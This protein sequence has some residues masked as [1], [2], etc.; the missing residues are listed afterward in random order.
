MKYLLLLIIGFFTINFAKSQ[1]IPSS[2][3]QIKYA[4]MALSEDA[5]KEATVLGY[6][7]NGELITLKKGTNNFICLADD[8][9]QNGFS[10]AAY[11]KDLEPYMARGR[12]LKKEGK[13]F[14]EIFKLRGEEIKAGKYEIPNNSTLNVMN[15]DFD[16]NGIP[17]KTYLRY[18]VYIPFA[19]AESTG[20]P[21]S[22]ITKGGPWIMNPGTYRAHIMI[23]P[24][25]TN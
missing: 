23:N 10:V 13:N 3:I 15:G 16:S 5:A 8:P 11:H 20:L 17:I 21:L 6:N 9:S 19:T 4:S 24:I 25:N 14:N 1:E 12:E 2:E 22:Q 7:A 18:V